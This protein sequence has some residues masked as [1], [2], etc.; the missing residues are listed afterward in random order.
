MIRDVQSIPACKKASDDAQEL[1]EEGYH[2]RS[3]ILPMQLQLVCS[4]EIALRSLHN[5]AH[6]Q[7]EDAKAW[8]QP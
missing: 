7:E 4:E 5:E 6:Q 1:G 8:S 2:V 3:E